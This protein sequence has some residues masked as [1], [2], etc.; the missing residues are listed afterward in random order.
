MNQ[1]NV[2]EGEVKELEILEFKTG[3]NSYGVN[4]N[5]IKEIL[6]Y[7]QKPTPI[8]NAHPYIEGMVMP[9]DFIIPIINLG[10]S[11]KLVN[12]SSSNEE[13]LMV[14]GINDLN[15]GFHVD[16]VQG[17]HRIFS[18]EIK[19]PGK[20]LS[21]KVKDVVTGTFERKNTVIELLD[22]RKLIT[23]INPDVLNQ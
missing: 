8:P 20:N 1:E 13:M 16:K 9:R 2:K 18:N 6:P 4:I 14:T 3:G 7:R 10:K 15:I 12:Q 11:L 21:T 17:I 19:E 22:L 23:I 5:E